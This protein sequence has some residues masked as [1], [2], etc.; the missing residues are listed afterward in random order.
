MKNK[1]L[2]IDCA[3]WR[4]GGASPE[5][6]L[7]FGDTRMLNDE[8]YMCC[9]GQLSLQLNGKLE[10]RS[11]LDRFVPGDCGARMRKIHIF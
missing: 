4:C 7:G 9:L 10:N 2:T 5:T 8:G 1:T 11:I 6:S 3:K